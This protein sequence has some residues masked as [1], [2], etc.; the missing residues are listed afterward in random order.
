MRYNVYDLFD[1][2]VRGDRLKEIALKLGYAKPAM[3]GKEEQDSLNIINWL[4]NLPPSIH[5][6]LQI[7]VK[8]K[9]MEYAS[10]SELFQDINFKNAIYNV[11]INAAH[12]AKLFDD[13]KKIH[14]KRDEIEKAVTELKQL[15][16]KEKQ[17]E[18]ERTQQDFALRQQ[19]AAQNQQLQQMIN[20]YIQQ[21]NAK[22]K[23]LE[24]AIKELNAKQREL[25]A[26]D[27]SILKEY[28]AEFAKDLDT[29]KN[30]QGESIFA[31]L[32]AEQKQE[33]AE[34]IA[35]KKFKIERKY[36]KEIEAL[37]QEREDINQQIATLKN[38]DPSKTT[39]MVTA[40]ARHKQQDTKQIKE[41]ETRRDQIDKKIEDK[42]KE[43]E[44]VFKREVESDLRKV[45]VDPKYTSQV[46]EKANNSKS[47][48]KQVELR[49]VV[50]DEIEVV[51][52]KTKEFKE[53]VQIVKEEINKIENIEQNEVNEIQKEINLISKE[54]NFQA[55]KQTEIDALI[56]PDNEIGAQINDLMDAN[57]I[58]FNFDIGVVEEGLDESLTSSDQFLISEVVEPSASLR[59]KLT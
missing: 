55:D 7:E 42:Q 49:S 21:R 15:V 41:L 57:S 26:F 12:L 4:N 30:D 51:Q 32:N 17:S 48:K 37:K 53:E 22:I 31:H 5:S 45:G 52:E 34:S 39:G 40:F 14:Y 44:A 3:T 25:M 20:D 16:E 19:I 24:D 47:I 23:E 29:I 56:M 2:N 8:F 50:H 27:K 6:L 9:N 33:L 28:S 10:I 35:D 58:D 54:S 11:A 1:G 13:L 46:V 59:T 18:K 38:G 36:N 43:K